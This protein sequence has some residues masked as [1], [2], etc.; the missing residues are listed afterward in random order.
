MSVICWR[1]F[2]AQTMLQAMRSLI[3]PQLSNILQTQSLISPSVCLLIQSLYVLLRNF[4][5]NRKLRNACRAENVADEKSSAHF[6][7]RFTSGLRIA[8]SWNNRCEVK[9]VD[10]YCV[11][12]RFYYYGQ[13]CVDRYALFYKNIMYKS[14]RLFRRCY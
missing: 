1:K 12:A 14:M 10:I 6:H 3:S 2:L 7:V 5:V 4:L 8:F 9:P 11:M 13:Y